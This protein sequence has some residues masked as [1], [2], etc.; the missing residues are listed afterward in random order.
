M[1]TACKILFPFCEQHQDL[2]WLAGW[3]SDTVSWVTLQ[4]QIILGIKQSSLVQLHWLIEALLWD[5]VL[6]QCFVKSYR[7]FAFQARRENE[8]FFLHFLFLFKYQGFISHLIKINGNLMLNSMSVFILK[9][10]FMQFW[11]FS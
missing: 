2:F 6:D 7:S 1:W 8:G 5:M 3:T 9:L 4:F 10:Q 11:D